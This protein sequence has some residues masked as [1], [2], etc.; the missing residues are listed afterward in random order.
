MHEQYIS[1]SSQYNDMSLSPQCN[2]AKIIW[3]AKGAAT[4][5]QYL[6]IIEQGFDGMGVYSKIQ[7]SKH[8]SNWKPERV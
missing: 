5:L 3:A 6:K 8:E 1:I 7:I 2:G 4:L